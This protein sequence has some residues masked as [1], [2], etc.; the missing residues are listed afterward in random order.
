LDSEGD[1]LLVGVA[2]G[3]L[4]WRVPA[5]VAQLGSTQS[6][7]A[8]G[9]PEL[10]AAVPMPMRCTFSSGAIGF[11]LGAAPL[12]W[13]GLQLTGPGFD[14]TGN[15]DLWQ[16]YKGN[17]SPPPAMPS[18]VRYKSNAGSQDIVAKAMRTSGEAID[19]LAETLR[20][21][22]DCR[23]IVAAGGV[24]SLRAWAVALSE[25]EAEALYAA[26]NGAEQTLAEAVRELRRWLRA[27]GH[28]RTGTK[29]AAK[30]D[31]ARTLA[32]WAEDCRRSVVWPLQVAF[33][34]DDTGA[35]GPAGDGEEDDD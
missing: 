23:G 21:A 4:L 1:V 34:A 17:E 7:G 32:K 20:K 26:A 13:V 10:L 30:A 3:V 16:F 8:L 35:E 19:K 11:G 9:E 5:L 2:K 25:R 33:E 14:G 18:T 6:I 12:G 22:N 27:A 31:G 15:L 29:A 28:G 24:A